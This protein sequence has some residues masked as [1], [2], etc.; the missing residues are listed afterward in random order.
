MDR[1]ESNHWTFCGDLGNFAFLLTITAVFE[2]TNECC[3]SK[4]FP[5]LPISPIL[6]IRHEI[7]H[8]SRDVAPHFDILILRNRPPL[9][10]K[11]YGFVLLDLLDH[12]IDVYLDN[13]CKIFP[14]QIIIRFQEDLTKPRFANWI[15]F[16][17]ELI[18]TMKRVTILSN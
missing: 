17:V 5:R 11:V 6:T 15:V 4:H 3:P 8:K 10:V 13:L 9:P 2:S 12:S 16:G 7:F 14:I 18:K 1:R